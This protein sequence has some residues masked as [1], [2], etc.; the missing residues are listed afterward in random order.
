M[1]GSTHSFL[2]KQYAI[3]EKIMACRRILKA[4]LSEILLV[5]CMFI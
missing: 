3:Q 1:T 4:N 2:L 5:N